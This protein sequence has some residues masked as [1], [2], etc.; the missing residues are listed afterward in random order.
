MSFEVYTPIY[1]GKESGHTLRPHGKGFDVAFSCD[2]KENTAYRLFTVGETEQYY[3]WKDEPDGPFMY[4][5]LTDGLDTKHAIRDRYC[6]SLSCKKYEDY[7]KRIYKKIMWLPKLSYLKMHS[8]PTAW[9]MGLTVSAKNLSISGKGFLQMRVDVRLQKDGVDS[10]CVYAPA[11]ISYVLPIEEG[12]YTGREFLKEI[13]IPANTAHVGVFVEGIGYKGECYIE[14][15]MLCGNGQNLLPSFN[16]SVSD[17]NHL[18]WAAQYISRKEWPEFRVR[19]NGKVIFTGEV[20][21]RS[22]RHSE[23]EISLPSKYLQ[24]DNLLTYELISDYHEPLPYTLYEVGVIEQPNAELS[25]LSVSQAAPAG[26]KARVLIKT[27]KQNMRVTLSCPDGKLSGKKEWLFRAKGLHG[28]L[29][30]CK[31]PCENASFRLAWDGGVVEGTVLQIVQKTQDRVIT[32]TGD[33]IYV[34]QDRESMEEYLSWYLA[35]H[36][37]DLVTIRPTYRWSGTRTINEQVWREFR[38][39]MNELNLKYVLMADGREIP[40]LSTQPSEELLRGKGFLGIQ[41]HENDGAQYYWSVREITSPTVEMFADMVYFAYAEKPEYTSSRHGKSHVRYVN[42]KAYFYAN[43]QLP[44]DYR[45]AHEQSVASL[46]AVRQQRDTRHTGPSALFR[47]MLEAGYSWVGAETMYQTMEPIMGFIRGV[48]KEYGLK[49][50]GVHHA[51]QWSSTPHESLARFRRFRLALYASYMEGATDINTEEG[52]WHL[53]EYYEHHHRFGK[54]CTAHL[55]QQQDFYRYVSSH[56]RTGSFYTPIAFLHGRDDGTTFFGKNKTWGFMEQQTAAE[57]SWDLLT[58]VYP[59]ANPVVSVYRHGCPDDVPQGYHSGTPYGNLDAISVEAKPAVFRDYRTLM[60]MGYNRCEA[61]EAQK[62]YNRV[63]SGAS[64]LLT[65]AHLTTTSNIADLHANHLSFEQ[66]ALSFCKGDPVFA[67]T[68]YRGVPVTVCTNAHTP[69]EVLATTDDGQPLVVVYRV[70]KG[71][72]VMFN[73][74]EYPSHAAIRA[75]YEEQMK[76]L[77]RE[78][79]DAEQIWASAGDDVSFAAYD[80]TDGTRHMYFLA[81]DW[82]R[83]PDFDRHAALRLGKT[84]YDVAL[85]FGIMLKCVCNESVAAWPVSED[86]EVLSIS[87]GT[88]TVQGTGKVD[89]RLAKGGALRTLT[90]DFTEKTVQTISL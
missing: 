36:V 32:G 76:T 15:P 73:T 55:R 47:C 25:V 90:V 34:H 66:N 49:T 46:A 28:M 19:L 83:A 21:E 13:E 11:D 89:F 4:R 82:Y 26:G 53:E 12:T 23:W 40:G 29:L 42:G 71:K 39:L 3:M 78:A 48:A 14:T 18:D 62:L 88:A 17:K 51:V 38:R 79:G 24:K 72:I 69:D 81:M 64:L 27:A 75:D 57:D 22:H 1:D 65:R 70:G 31:E 5:M 50:Y 77:C 80:Q 43:R 63:R 44:A 33:M 85:P 9:T 60:F 52:L 20:F 35:N 74:R 61:E 84:V 8:V 58:A 6:L 59:K 56:S 45:S 16:E 68:T 2:R 67:D 37:G 86:G 54:A 87:N 30:D 7:L 41:L 10:R